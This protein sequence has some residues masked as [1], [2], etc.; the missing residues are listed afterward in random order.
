MFTQPICTSDSAWKLYT[1][2]S[3]L[4]LQTHLNGGTVCAC[5]YKV[6][7]GQPR[8][9]QVTASLSLTLIQ[10]LRGNI[11]LGDLTF[12]YNLDSFQIL[13]DFVH[14]ADKKTK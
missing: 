9:C 5:Q 10:H 3:V 11:G 6:C 12:K 1:G 7:V 8:T 2:A 14:W 13:N 4:S